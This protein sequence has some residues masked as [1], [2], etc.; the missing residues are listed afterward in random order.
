MTGRV[1]ALTFGLL[2]AL[3]QTGYFF[4][5]SVR[6]T[7]AYPSYLTVLV[8]WLAGS[9]VGL[10][11][12]RRHGGTLRWI[13][14]AL[15]AYY[16]SYGLLR[17]FPYDLSLLPL[18]AVAVFVCGIMA[19]VFFVEARPLLPTA[20]ALFFWENNG[21]VLGWLVGFFGYVKGAETFTLA[22]PPAVAALAWL[23]RSLFL[24]PPRNRS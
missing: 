11:M 17:L 7:A 19:G 13:G 9:A 12:A 2:L 3:L 10:A 21:F 20:A 1:F 14:A 16:V 18:H 23:I 22:A 24:S 5:L 4:H 6:L 8:G 15:L